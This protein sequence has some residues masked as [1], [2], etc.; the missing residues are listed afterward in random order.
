MW[1]ER[2]MKIKERETA[3]WLSKPP[4]VDVTNGA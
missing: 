4:L 2:K 1:E 3:K